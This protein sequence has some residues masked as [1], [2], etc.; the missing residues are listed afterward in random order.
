MPKHCIFKSQLSVLVMLRK[1]LLCEYYLANKKSDSE[2]L[3]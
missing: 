3:V 2:C 1:P